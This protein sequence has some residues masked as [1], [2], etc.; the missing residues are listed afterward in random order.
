MHKVNEL[1]EL[2]QLRVIFFSVQ[3]DAI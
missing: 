1:N 3:I 2:E